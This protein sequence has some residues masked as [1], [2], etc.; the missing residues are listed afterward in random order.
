MEAIF[1][2]TDPCDDVEWPCS[3]RVFLESDDEGDTLPMVCPYDSTHRPNWR[4]SA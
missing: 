4:K 1:T 3:L 2:C